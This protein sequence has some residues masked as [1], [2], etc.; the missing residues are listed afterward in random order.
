M[1]YGVVFGGADRPVIAMMTERTVEVLAVMG[2]TLD[3]PGED[4]ELGAPLVIGGP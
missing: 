3:R 4:D 1:A 2:F